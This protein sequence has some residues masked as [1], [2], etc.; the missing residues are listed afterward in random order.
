MA[1][2][3]MSQSPRQV[4]EK[5]WHAIAGDEGAA[6]ELLASAHIRK[7]KRLARLEVVR[8]ESLHDAKRLA[9]VVL[10]DPMVILATFAECLKKRGV[11]IG[12]RGG[13]SYLQVA[14]YGLSIDLWK[15]SDQPAILREQMCRN[16]KLSWVHS[17]GLMDATRNKLALEIAERT[18]APHPRQFIRNGGI[19]AFEKWLSAN[20]DQSTA[21]ITTDIPDCFGNIRRSLA[22]AGLLLPEWVSKRAMFDPMDH[23]IALIPN[24]KGKLIPANT[25]DHIVAVSSAKRGIPKGAALSAVAS[26]AVLKIVLEAVEASAPGVTAAS[27]GDNLIFLL[28]DASA[29]SPVE[30][31][32]T[33]SVAKCFGMDVIAE[34]TRRN[35]LSGTNQWF[36]FCGR[37][38]REKNGE[39]QV[40][41]EEARIDNYMI[42]FEVTLGDAQT[43]RDFERLESSVRGWTA[44]H[45]HSSKVL[46]EGISAAILLGET[47]EHKAR[48]TGLATET[49]LETIPIP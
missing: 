27:I 12:G 33:L 14:E 11:K 39:L 37:S 18:V 7:R 9:R 20:L 26:E 17:L 44:S 43:E 46:M 3:P 47:K 35:S 31:A 34:L 38:Y 25:K 8:L 19:P 13:E 4:S 5:L 23:A 15:Q 30:N 49:P 32:L 29:V 45:R 40:R 28:E 36:S 42:K 1:T 2:K 6:S 24:A 21:V 22:S 41:T 48:T 10:S 16:G